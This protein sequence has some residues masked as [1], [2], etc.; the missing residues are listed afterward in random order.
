MQP[1]RTRGRRRAEC[2]VQLIAIRA[3]IVSEDTRAGMHRRRLR[4]VMPDISR[5]TSGT[6]RW[7]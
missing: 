7:I 3:A 6:V 2:D 4:V 1:K 5:L